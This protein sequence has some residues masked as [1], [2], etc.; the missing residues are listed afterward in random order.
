MDRLTIV[1]IGGAL[2]DREEEFG[3]LLD[4]FAALD[5]AKI[6]VHG[7]GPQ[8]DRIGRKL[9]IEPVMRNGRRLTDADTL[10]LVTMVYAGLNAKRI[11]AGLQSRG[12][13]ALGLS[14]ADGNV[15]A[16]RKRP[17]GEI[18][19]GF[20]GDLYPDDVNVGLFD[21]LLTNGFVPL[22]SPITHDG[23]GGLLN[24]NADTIASVVA[25]A[26][27]DR[28]DV[29]LTYVLD[30][31]GV[32]SD[33]ADD[34][35]VLPSLTATEIERMK[36]DGGIGGGMFPKLENALAALAGGVADVKICGAD[37]VADDAA[38]TNILDDR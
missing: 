15:L 12:C 37:G 14:G 10:E 32:L 27:A 13:N 22:L 4:A 36:E 11:A 20:V 28:Y 19:F 9:G 6:L 1:K 31:G 21:M 34:A 8:A 2:L 35:S 25:C 18:D 29:G 17:V 38:G 7:G 30:K 16:A 5:G 26:M 24:T 3:R 23:L 33:P